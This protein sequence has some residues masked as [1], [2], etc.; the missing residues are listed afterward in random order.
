MKQ[1]IVDEVIKEMSGGNVYLET[2]L[3]TVSNIGKD[4][5]GRWSDSAVPKLKTRLRSGV[6]YLVGGRISFEEIAKDSQNFWQ[7]PQGQLEDQLLRDYIVPRLIKG[8]KK[9]NF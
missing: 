1:E 4:V 6:Q 3:R 7:S 9:H 5:I 8:A 2:L